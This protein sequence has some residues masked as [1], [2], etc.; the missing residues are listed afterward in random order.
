M[1]ILQT[2]LGEPG[3]FVGEILDQLNGI[4][5][6]LSPPQVH[7]FYEAV[8]DLISAEHET[9][10]QERLIERLMQLPNAVWDEIMNHASQVGGSSGGG[11]MK[12]GCECG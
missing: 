3:P 4:I 2:Q 10:K 7:V 8:G 12:P 11:R 5:C 6:D 9:G 1:P